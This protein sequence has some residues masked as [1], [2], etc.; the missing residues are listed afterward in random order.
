MLFQSSRTSFSLLTATA[1]LF[2]F[3]ITCASAFAQDVEPPVHHTWSIKLG[4]FIPDSGGMMNISSVP[5]FAG[6]IDYFPASTFR[7][8]NAQLH[9]GVDFAES[10]KHGNTNLII[11]VTAKLIWPIPINSSSFRPYFGLGGGLYFINAAFMGGTTQPGIKAIVGFD[12]SQRFFLEA[13][14]DYVS[15]FSNDMG[16]GLR[17]DGTTIYVGMRF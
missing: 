12:I 8:C 2:V 11:P 13:N 4:A 15:G 3:I 17:A 16:T 5:W 14:Y 10:D 7:P 9:F 6:G 1:V